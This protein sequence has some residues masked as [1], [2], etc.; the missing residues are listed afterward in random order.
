MIGGH[1][2]RAHAAG[3]AEP[4][5]MLHGARALRASFRM[6]ARRFLGIEKNATYAVPVE[7]QRE[8]QP[9]RPAADDC[10]RYT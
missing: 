2:E 10:D 9:D 8:H 4:A 1:A 7:Q 3:D 6:P 5:V